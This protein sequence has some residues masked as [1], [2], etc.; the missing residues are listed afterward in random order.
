MSQMVAAMPENKQRW[1]EY[2]GTK[3]D[4]EVLRLMRAACAIEGVRMQDWLSDLVNE[5]A[6]EILGRNPIKRKPPKPKDKD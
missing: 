1:C 3:I 6:S 2:T 4:A 5:A